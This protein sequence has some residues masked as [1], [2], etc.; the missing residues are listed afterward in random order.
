M[1]MK[2]IRLLIGGSEIARVTDGIFSNT[3]T[4]MGIC[5]PNF[6]QWYEDC[7]YGLKGTRTFEERFE[8]VKSGKYFCYSK[9]CLKLEAVEE[10]DD[11]LPE[12]KA[13]G[14]KNMEM[15]IKGFA[16]SL[17]MLV[18]IEGYDGYLLESG[19]SGN[20]GSEHLVDLGYGRIFRTEY[21]NLHLVLFE[22]NKLIFHELPLGKIKIKNF[23]NEKGYSCKIAADYK[24]VP[25][26]RTSWKV[27]M[28]E[29][30]A[31]FS[32]KGFALQYR[33]WLDYTFYQ[34]ELNILDRGWIRVGGHDIQ[35]FEMWNVM[36]DILG[37]FEESICKALSSSQ[38]ITGKQMAD[39]FR[40]AK[41]EDEIGYLRMYERDDE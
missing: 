23:L 14:E 7:F 34:F 32:S 1:L 19:N 15:I 5:P 6:A 30:Q 39:L 27:A 29:R 36:E 3:I 35:R 8:A 33:G 11:R 38:D 40:N 31:V 12:N 21:E 24:S 37:I 4:P 25:G 26:L 9:P 16:S 2:I 28:K 41:I 22:R 18:H 13:E 20:S 17:K 10:Q